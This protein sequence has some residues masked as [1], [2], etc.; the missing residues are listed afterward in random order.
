MA[1]LIKR[2]LEESRWLALIQLKK[3]FFLIYIA[4]DQSYFIP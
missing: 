1:S 2:G 4:S 3:V